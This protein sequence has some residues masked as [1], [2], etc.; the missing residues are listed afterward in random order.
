VKLGLI[1]CLAER[2]EYVMRGEIQMTSGTTRDLIKAGSLIVVPAHTTITVQSA[3]PLNTV[4]AEFI[5]APS[6][7]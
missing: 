3:G 2:F 4:L 7:R 1:T 5:P 6:E